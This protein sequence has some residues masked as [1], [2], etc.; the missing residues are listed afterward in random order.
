MYAAFN[1]RDI[2]A[3]LDHMTPDVD[4]PNA[5]ERGRVHRHEELRDYW[6]RQ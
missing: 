4:W 6:S 2:D 1:A 3:L 5:W